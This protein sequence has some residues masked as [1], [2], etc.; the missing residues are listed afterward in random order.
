MQTDEASFAS[1][2]VAES[3]IGQPS[4]PIENEDIEVVLPDNTDIV[5]PTE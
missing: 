2:M 3:L 4:L 5:I 1:L